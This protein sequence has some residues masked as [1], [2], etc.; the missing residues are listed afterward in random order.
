[1]D[2]EVKRAQLSTEFET[3]ERCFILEVANDGNDQDFRFR[4][5]AYR[6]A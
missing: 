3:P 5:R 2:A 6:L 4:V 1:M